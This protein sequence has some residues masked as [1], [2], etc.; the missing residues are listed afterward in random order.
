MRK[1][2]REWQERNPDKMKEIRARSAQQAKWDREAIDAV[3]YAW[4][5]EQ[6]RFRAEYIREHGTTDGMLQAVAEHY[7]VWLETLLP[8]ERALQEWLWPH[9]GPTASTERLRKTPWRG[10][11]RKPTVKEWRHFIER[12]QAENPEGTT[13]T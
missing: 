2:I 4:P 8:L 10:S 6:V 9:L 1:K 13:G 11:L 12:W 5:K 7:G 3:R